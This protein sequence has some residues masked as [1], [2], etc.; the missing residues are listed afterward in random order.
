LLKAEQYEPIFLD[1]EMK[2]TLFK[3]RVALKK[4]KKNK[5]SRNKDVFM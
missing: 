5:L 2:V 1:L 3:G 4:R